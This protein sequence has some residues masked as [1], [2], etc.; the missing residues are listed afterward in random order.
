[1]SEDE[2]RQDNDSGLSRREEKIVDQRLRLRA[3]MVYQI[4][5]HE[6]EEEMTRGVPALWWSGL[7][8]GL[9]IGFSMVAQGALR[10]ELEHLP[11]HAL[12]DSFGY[13]VGFLIVVLGRQQ[14]FTENT[15]TVVLPVMA[16]TTYGNFI[17]LVRMWSIVFAA[18]MVGAALF[19][20]F[21]AYG[22]VFADDVM[23]AFVDIGH[24]ML[25]NSAIESF[26]KGIGSGWLI[27]A[28]VWLMPSAQ[29]SRFWVV[30]AITYF[31]ALA[32]FT[33]IVAGA[34]E[35]LFMLFIGEAALSGVLLDFMLPTLFGNI[36]GGSALFA[37]ISYAQVRREI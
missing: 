17:C 15:I 27:A 22:N 34:V 20:L 10:A 30:I 3:A 1:M 13:C 8:A 31:I 18:N 32:E 14:L 5:R 23:A 37:L 33:H 11:W 26:V 2:E 25:A 35:A 19:A 24:H 36:V 12:I 29:A 4:V 21:V 7:A 28:M 6:G 9:S 16:E